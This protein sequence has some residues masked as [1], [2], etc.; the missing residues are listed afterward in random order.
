MAKENLDRFKPKRKGDDGRALRAA[1][2]AAS[3]GR[4]SDRRFV[5]HLEHEQGA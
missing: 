4:P 1:V 5:G 2:H 3:E